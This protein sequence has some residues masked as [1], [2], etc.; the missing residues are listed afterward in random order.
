MGLTAAEILAQEDR[1]VKRVNTPEWG[2]DAHVF[3]RSI[4]TE[5]AIA[6]TEQLGGGKD[7][8]LIMAAQAASF[9][10]DE[11]GVALFADASAAT[12]FMKRKATVVKRI[13]NAGLLL[14][15]SESQAAEKEK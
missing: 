3:V 4:S 14:N 13:I 7:Q 8:V 10:C 5:E 15:H 11:N 12:P 9:L 2:K 1:V 6:L